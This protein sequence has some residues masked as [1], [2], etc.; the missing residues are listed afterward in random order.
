MRFAARRMNS[1]PLEGLYMTST[2]VLIRLLGSSVLTLRP[3]SETSSRTLPSTDLASSVAST[4]ASPRERSTSSAR[5]A[6]KEVIRSTGERHSANREEMWFSPYMRTRLPVMTISRYP[7]STRRSCTGALISRRYSSF[8]VSRFHTRMVPS[9]A[10]ERNRPG[11]L[12]K[13]RAVTVPACPWK[14]WTSE[15]PRAE[16][17]TLTLPSFPLVI[18]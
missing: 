8:S 17:Q 2:I 16:L 15:L 1:S 10:P 4:A 12:W 11:W 18:K 9:I 14:T 5:T 13:A 6:G 7:G 3:V